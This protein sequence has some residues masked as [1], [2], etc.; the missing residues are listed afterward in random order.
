MKQGHRSVPYSPWL[1]GIAAAFLLFVL[2][3]VK[4]EEFGAAGRDVLGWFSK[5][6]LPFYITWFDKTYVALPRLLHVLALVYVLSSIGTIRRFAESRYAAPLALLG[7]FGLPVFATGSV[8]SM[9]GQAIKA[10]TGENAVADFLIIFTGLALQL[11]LAFTL[12]RIVAARS[13]AAEAKTHP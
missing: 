10:G 1:L 11:G 9:L 13:R 5:M 7:R 3:W 12:S 4:W 8:L 2:V 6:G